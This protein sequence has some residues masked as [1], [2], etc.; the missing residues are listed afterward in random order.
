MHREG[1]PRAQTFLLPPGTCRAS[2][3][4][5]LSADATKAPPVTAKDLGIDTLEI[6]RVCLLAGETRERAQLLL[7]KGKQGRS[8]SSP[9]AIEAACHALLTAA[10]V[11]HA[12]VQT[13]QA[14]I[15]DG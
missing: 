13:P 1:R 7:L 2:A 9:A 4:A 8:E 12:V 11:P 5:G 15:F 3:T 6:K 10:N 14:S